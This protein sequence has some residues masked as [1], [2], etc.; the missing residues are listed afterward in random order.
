MVAVRVTRIVFVSTD[1]LLQV[2]PLNQFLDIS[3]QVIAILDFVPN[4]PVIGT[5]EVGIPLFPSSS[6][7]GRSPSEAILLHDGKDMGTISVQRSDWNLERLT[8]P[9]QF[10]QKLSDG[11]GQ[12]YGN[13]P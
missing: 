5:V 11:L 12:S 9:W 4:V 7:S 13:H 2:P 6:H 1:E 8:F 10:C 3:F